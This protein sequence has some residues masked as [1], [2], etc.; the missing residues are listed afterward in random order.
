M[1]LCLESK[2][3]ITSIT[4]MIQ[5]EVADPFSIHSGGKEIPGAIKL[6]SVLLWGNRKLLEFCARKFFIP[7]PSVTSE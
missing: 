6:Y 4:V 2:I 5:K 3:D 1:K 7:E